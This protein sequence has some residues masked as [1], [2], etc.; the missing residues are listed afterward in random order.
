MSIPMQNA[1]SSAN[2]SKTTNSELLSTAM[3][4]S[5]AIQQA[6]A[7]IPQFDG[8][9]IPLK[10]FLL[11]V[12]NSAYCLPPT[13]DGSFTRAVISKL[14][15]EARD[16]ICD[17]QFRTIN[18]LVRH[19]KRRFSS[20]KTY[21]YYQQ[22]ISNIR[23]KRNESVYAFYDR[24]RILINGIYHCLKDTYGDDE[25][26]MLR[27]VKSTA[28]NAF[29]RGLPD[30]LARAVEARDP[31][32]L[33]KALE[34]AIKVEERMNTGV[35]P[36]YEHHKP[37]QTS[38]IRHNYRSQGNYRSD[39]YREYSNDTHQNP[40]TSLY[41]YQAREYQNY[42]VQ[43]ENRSR[44]PSPYRAFKYPHSYQNCCCQHNQPMQHRCCHFPNMP[45]C[46]SNSHG[47][48][49]NFTDTKP[50][51]RDNVELKSRS[52]S[53]NPNVS[54]STTPTNQPSIVRRR[55]PSPHSAKPNLEKSANL[56]SQPARRVDATMSSK[57]TERH[58]TV[59]FLEE[60]EHCLP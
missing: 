17:L 44:T 12:Q 31:D 1:A 58:P 4:K 9:N 25:S 36:S 11:D 15:G 6:V 45:P 24:L 57:Q 38:D 54:F 35:I 16:S 33:E 40:H 41:P 52:S 19:L 59:K 46:C 3:A 60:N 10:D 20:G 14:R 39:S 13:C 7:N 43:N 37:F 23:M 8:N 28:I 47:N 48:H 42:P 51:R 18:D 26:N 22:E 21:E 27:P 55:S 29:I 53:P 34:I 49:I 5:F 56:N 30:E 50:Y 2:D 32:D